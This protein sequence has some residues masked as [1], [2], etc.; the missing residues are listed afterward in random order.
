MFESDAIGS[1]ENAGA[2]FAK[3]TMNKNPLERGL[4]K[5]GEV[6][7]E[8]LGSRRAESVDRNRNKMHAES[9]GFRA[10]AL[11]KMRRFEAKIDDC[12]DAKF[13]KFVKI[14]DTRLRAAKK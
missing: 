7:G 2:I 1:D 8:L 14:F 12:R 3:L 5:K 13:L 4:A 9:S 6:F 10:F 11:A